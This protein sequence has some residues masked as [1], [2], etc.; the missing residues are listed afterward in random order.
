MRMVTSELKVLTFEI[1]FLIFVVVPINSGLQLENSNKGISISLDVTSAVI[2]A[3]DSTVFCF[4]FAL[5]YEA[6]V[7]RDAENMSSSELSPSQSE[8]IAS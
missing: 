7:D 8:G 5:T 1:F 3:I 6:F 2:S 4:S